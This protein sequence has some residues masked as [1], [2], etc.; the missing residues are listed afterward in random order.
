VIRLLARTALSFGCFLLL[1]SGVL[2]FALRP[3]TNQFAI[4]IFNMI[5]GGAMIG[6]GIVLSLRFTRRKTTKEDL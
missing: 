1:A 2:L 3:G 5:M 4:T 6:V